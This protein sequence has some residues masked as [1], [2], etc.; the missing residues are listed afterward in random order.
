MVNKRRIKEICRLAWD[1]N[2]TGNDIDR[3]E[4]ELLTDWKTYKD[5]DDSEIID[6]IMYP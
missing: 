3:I 6:K 5:M 4:F 2:F 1:R